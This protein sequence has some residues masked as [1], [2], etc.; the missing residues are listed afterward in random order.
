MIQFKAECEAYRCHGQLIRKHLSFN[1]L[2]PDRQAIQH[3]Q[4][5]AR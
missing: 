3:E 4:Y 1:I 5:Q 2:F